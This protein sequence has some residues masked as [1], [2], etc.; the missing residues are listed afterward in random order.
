MD[1]LNEISNK[2]KHDNKG[3]VIG[4]AISIYRTDRS[5]YAWGLN[6]NYLTDVLNKTGCSYSLSPG[7]VK[8]HGSWRGEDKQCD[9][10][11]E[12]AFTVWQIRN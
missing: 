5:E 2:G 1:P 10:E 12:I 3:Y 9:C 11:C 6:A 8:S 7:L 4:I